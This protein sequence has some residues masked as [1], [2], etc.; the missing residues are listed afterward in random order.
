MGKALLSN[1]KN[2][3]VNIFLILM[4]ESIVHPRNI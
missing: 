4:L 3:P 2:L 1:P